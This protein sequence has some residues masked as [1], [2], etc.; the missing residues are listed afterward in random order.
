MHN[1]AAQT[2]NLFEAPDLRKLRCGDVPFVITPGVV[3]TVLLDISTF[4]AEQA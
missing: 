1:C 4:H 3:D 2:R